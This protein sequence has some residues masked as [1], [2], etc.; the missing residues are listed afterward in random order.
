MKPFDGRNLLDHL[1][2]DRQQV[3]LADA[4]AAG[5]HLPLGEDVHGID[6]ID[7]L[8]A[9]QIALVDR[10]NA[11]DA[12]CDFVG[13]S[14]VLLS[15][16]PIW[17]ARRL[18]PAHKMVPCAQ[19]LATP[20]VGDARSVLLQQYVYSPGHQHGNQP[21]VAVQGIGK[22]HIAFGESLEQ[23]AHKPKFAAALATVWSYRHIQR[24]AAGQA[25]HHD[26]SRRREANPRRLG[27]GLGV[28]FLVL[29][30][31][32]HRYAGAVYQLYRAPAPQPLLE[33]LLS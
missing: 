13:K 25:N 23:T 19:R 4:L 14:R 1:L 7:T 9:V 22:H 30:G 28:V 33:R 32:G 29:G 20:K 5:H 11:D 15:C 27:T 12:H 31:I 10:I 2:Q 26:Q 17:A 3:C 16:H 21:I 24:G 6:V 18:G 8:G